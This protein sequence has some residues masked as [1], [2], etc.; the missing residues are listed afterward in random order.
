MSR[1]FDLLVFDW[2][3]TLMDSTGTIARSIQAAFA[4]VGLPVPDDQDARYVIGYGLNEAMQHLAPGVDDAM[5]KRIVDAYRHHYLSGDH[6]LLL[7]DGVREGLD[8]FADAGFEMAVATG[9]SRAGLDR[10]LASTGLGRYFVATR[11]AD[12]TFSKPHPAML[13]QL[14][15]VT[16]NVA[17]RAVMIGDTT[18]DLQLAINAGCASLGMSYGAHP[19]DQLLTCAPL[20]IFDDFPSLTRWVLAHE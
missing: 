11:T 18:H 7:Y 6:A 4:D 14:L 13:E 8:A 17:D 16:F 12:E 1:R 5:I 20:A 15:D 3:G 2:D 19:V 10:V 9:K